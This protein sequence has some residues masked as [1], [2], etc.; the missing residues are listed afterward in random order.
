MTDP[1]L[2]V[3]RK[4]RQSL[5]VLRHEKE[6]VVTESILSTR[7]LKE[8][9]SQFPRKLSASAIRKAISN[10]TLKASAS[11]VIGN[12]CHQRKKLSVVIIVSG[13]LAG[14]PR[15][16]NPRLPIQSIDNQ[17]RIVG[18]SRLAGSNCNRTGFFY[19]I[20][21]ERYTILKDRWYSRII[22]KR[23]QMLHSAVQKKLKLP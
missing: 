11:A 20:F 21:F 2:Q 19:G 12:I 3:Q 17:P 8:N 23:I 5:T 22:P 13:I 18:N 9:A 10:N 14:K 16:I 4:L 6:R 7:L 1:V 15:R